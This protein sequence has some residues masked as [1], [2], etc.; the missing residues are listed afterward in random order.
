M[1]MDVVWDYLHEM[2]AD[3]ALSAFSQRDDMIEKQRLAATREVQ[4]FLD[5]NPNAEGREDQFR[6]G[7]MLE[8]PLPIVVETVEETKVF[9]PLSKTN[10]K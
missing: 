7:F 9:Q 3:H 1:V 4:S 2:S 6:F 8:E 10:P 5:N